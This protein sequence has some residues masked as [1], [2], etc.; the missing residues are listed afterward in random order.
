VTRVERFLSKLA[1][2]DHVG[3]AEYRAIHEVLTGDT[4]ESLDLVEAILHEFIDQAEALLEDA[5]RPRRAP[6]QTVLLELRQVK[7]SE[8]RVLL[9]VRAEHPLHVQVVSLVNGMVED[10]RV[11]KMSAAHLAAVCDYD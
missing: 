2:P 11:G 8:D 6:C 4:P 1:D 10:E 7:N 3:Q 5:G 9:K